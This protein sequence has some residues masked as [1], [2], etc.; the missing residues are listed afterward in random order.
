[1]STPSKSDKDRIS[2]YQ[3]LL[4]ASASYT[5]KTFTKRADRMVQLDKINHYLDENNKPTK[6]NSDRIKVA[7]PYRVVRQIL[8]ETYVKTPEPIVK[9]TRKPTPE[10]DT[11]NGAKKMK[12]GLEYITRK[13]NLKAEAKR[14]VHDGTSTGVG[15][16]FM[17]AQKKSKVPRYE[18]KLYRDVLFSSD[19]DDV[20]KSP[21]VAMKVVRPLDDIK[22]DKSYG[23][24]RDR[25]SAAKLDGTL[26]NNSDLPYGILWDYYDKKADVHCVFGDGQKEFLTDEKL[27]D[28]FRFSSDNDEFATDWPFFFYINEREIDSPFGMGDIYPIEAQSKELDKTRTQQV[29]HRKR[30][31]RKYLM[32][33]GFLDDQGRRQFQSDEDNVLVE[34]TKEI[35]PTEFTE[36]PVA[37]LSADVYKN[38]SDIYEDMQRIAP[39]GPDS[40]NSG[41]GAAPDTLGQAQIIEQNSQPRM[42]EKRD[43]ISDF[44]ARIYRLT[45]QFM[46]QYWV[47]QDVLLVT[48]DGSKPTDWLE[49]NPAE[50]TGEYAFEVDPETLRDNNASYRRQAAEALQV[51]T[52]ILSQ[53][54]PPGLAVL[55]RK[56]LETFD[57]GDIDAIIPDTDPNA[58]AAGD[59]AQTPE[60]KQLLDLINNT[61]PQ[62]FIDK[63]NSLP[64]N[65]RQQIRATIQ[66]LHGQQG[67][68]TGPS[69]ALGAPPQSP[70]APQP[71]P[72]VVTPQ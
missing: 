10:D 69:P 64:D 53:V 70:M 31:N 37:N 61:D 67:A 7:Y 32:H 9:P 35:S 17:T 54:N 56:Y 63:V 25:V 14:V 46:Q 1:M 68:P 42:N 60:E 23:P 3:S 20:Y 21:W 41:V 59:Q 51:S 13:S 27:T 65:E 57:F 66:R 55:L 30:S 6:A 33:K 24:A 48:G 11:I 15:I 49:W 26:Y 47:D 45:G 38:S 34:T 29:N 18:R 43:N 44:F 16:L 5:E 71:Q 36:V 8:S 19:V 12:A 2:R 72:P 40:L 50:V 62:Q 22:D 58:A 39:L 4:K 52:P 28:L